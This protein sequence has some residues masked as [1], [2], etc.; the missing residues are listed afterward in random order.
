MVDSLP[1]SQRRSTMSKKLRYPRFLL[2]YLRC[3]T[4][5]DIFLPEPQMYLN[6]RTSMFCDGVLMESLRGH[7]LFFHVFRRLLGIPPPAGVWKMDGWM[8]KQSTP[9]ITPGFAGGIK[10]M[11]EACFPDHYCTRSLITITHSIFPNT[12][13]FF[14]C[15]ATTCT[16][17]APAGP[18]SFSFCLFGCL[19][20]S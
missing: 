6:P 16:P 4:P 20:V 8:E 14:P 12:R 11:L 9:D 2:C 13:R 3:L 10:D 18:T 5:L 1:T 15:P 17:G 7:S 19:L